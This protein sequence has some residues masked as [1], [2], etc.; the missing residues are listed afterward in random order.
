MSDAITILL[1]E[2]NP[3]DVRLVREGFK[4]ADSEVA[5]QVATDGQEAL[6]MLSALQREE[7]VSRPD[8]IL[9]DLNLPRVD[10]FELLREIGTDAALR[11]IPTIILSSSEANEDIAKSYNLCANAYLIK[12]VNPAEFVSLARSIET[13]WF[14]KAEL[15]SL[16]A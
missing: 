11:S 3:G 16:S 4:Q 9:L 1:V 7:S 10:G 15:P 6:E 5:F 14:D 2:D 12:P 13:F 8:L